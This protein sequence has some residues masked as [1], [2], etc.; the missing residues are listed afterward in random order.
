MN[1]EIRK[2]FLFDRSHQM[3]CTLEHLIIT[4]SFHSHFIM[5]DYEGLL[6]LSKASYGFCFK[7]LILIHRN[8]FHFQVVSLISHCDVLVYC[9]T[10]T[11]FSPL[12]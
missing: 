12:F 4:F 8:N 11:P 7:L 1:H 5:I 10:L 3:C 9:W 2:L 6:P